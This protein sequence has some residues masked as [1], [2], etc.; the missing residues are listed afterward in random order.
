MCEDV[1]N[2]HGIIGVSIKSKLCWTG[3]WM[4]GRK[5]D[6]KCGTAEAHI[7]CT[8]N[9]EDSSALKEYDLAYDIGVKLAMDHLIVNACTTDGDSTSV[10]GLQD[11]LSAFLGKLISVERLADSRA[12][13]NSELA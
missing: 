9:T 6:P 2:D 12:R 8:A 1:T 4:L 5:L 3:A 10:K 11:G 13:P 7:G